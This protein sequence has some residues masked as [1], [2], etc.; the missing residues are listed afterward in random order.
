MDITRHRFL[1]VR[2]GEYESFEFSATVRAS[3]HDL[4]FADDIWVAVTQ[5][6]REKHAI[7]LQALL[8]AELDAAMADDIADAAAL[9]GDRKSFIHRITTEK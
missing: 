3:H 9:T 2:M 4:G 1:R 5:D 6:D 7:T 8:A